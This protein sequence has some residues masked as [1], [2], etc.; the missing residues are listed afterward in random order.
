MQRNN[1]LMP[2]PSQPLLKHLLKGEDGASSTPPSP[3][4]NRWH[5][6]SD[7]DWGKPVDCGGKARK[8]LRGGG[9]RGDRGGVRSLYSPCHRIEYAAVAAPKAIGA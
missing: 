3:Q 5:T 8:A 7:K 1:I 6:M 2:P 4:R 9:R